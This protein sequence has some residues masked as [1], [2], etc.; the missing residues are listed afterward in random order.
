MAFKALTDRM[1]LIY[2]LAA[3]L[4]LA[5]NF[6]QFIFCNLSPF[7]ANFFFTLLTMSFGLFVTAQVK[8]LLDEVT[9]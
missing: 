2:S 7:T 5:E 3:I 8:G 6:A 1:S 4:A 9:V